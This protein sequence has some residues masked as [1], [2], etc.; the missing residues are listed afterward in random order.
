[1]DAKLDSN[2]INSTDMDRI[3]YRWKMIDDGLWMMLKWEAK[4]DLASKKKEKK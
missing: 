3:N 4:P 2:G 1:M